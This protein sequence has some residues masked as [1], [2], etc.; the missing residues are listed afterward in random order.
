MPQASGTF[1]VTLTPQTGEIETSTPII[2]RNRIDK[3][4][5]G[6]LTGIS[7]GQ[8]LAAFMSEESAVYSALEYV[9]ATLHG[10][11]GTFMLQHTGISHHGNGE[12]TI[13]VVPDSGTGELRG[14]SGNMTIV[15]DGGQHAYTF[16]YTLPAE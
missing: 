2:K 6:D 9:S 16:E 7:V 5:H 3:V 13:T 11:G 10:R 14:L 8:M 1:D 12:L 4:F 15:N